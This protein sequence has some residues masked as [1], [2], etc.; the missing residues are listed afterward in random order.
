[1][2]NLH[3]ILHLICVKTSGNWLENSS[4]FKHCFGFEVEATVEPGHR[5]KSL[6]FKNLQVLTHSLTRAWLDWFSCREISTKRVVQTSPYICWHK[7]HAIPKEGFFCILAHEVF[8]LAQRIFLG[9]VW[10]S[11]TRCPVVANSLCTFTKIFSAS[12]ESTRFLC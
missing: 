4:D 6:S 11:N 3:K 5:V 9:I 2:S 7:S 10:L 12:A 8:V 1:M